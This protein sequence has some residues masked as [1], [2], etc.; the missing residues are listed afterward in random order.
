MIHVVNH[1]ERDRIYDVKSDKA[2]FI[3]IAS[4]VPIVL[5]HL[6]SAAREYLKLET[7]W[8]GGAPEIEL[9]EMSLRQLRALGYSIED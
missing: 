1:P 2:E 8:E 7:P 6:Q 9:D 4:E 5:N 3:N